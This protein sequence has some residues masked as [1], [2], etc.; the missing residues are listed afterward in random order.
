MEDEQQTIYDDEISETR[1]FYELLNHDFLVEDALQTID[2]INWDF[3]NFSTQ[4]K[5]K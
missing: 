4:L 1:A 3:K 2:K 5:L